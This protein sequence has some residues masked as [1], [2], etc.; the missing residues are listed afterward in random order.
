MPKPVKP[1][2]LFLIL[3][4]DTTELTNSIIV[5]WSCSPYVQSNGAAWIATA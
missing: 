2:L 4:D 3:K 5:Q 1:F